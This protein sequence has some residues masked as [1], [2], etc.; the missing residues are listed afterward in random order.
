MQ[1]PQ[2]PPLQTNRGITAQPLHTLILRVNIID[3]FCATLSN[4]KVP[5]STLAVSWTRENNT[6]TVKYLDW[7]KKN[8]HYLH[9]EKEE[10]IIEDQQMIVIQGSGKFI[11]YR[12]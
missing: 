7:I 1:G 9:H 11:F 12:E 10:F 3:F 5:E 2:P 4:N 6:V 8:N